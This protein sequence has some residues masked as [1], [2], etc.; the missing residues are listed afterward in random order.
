[1]TKTRSKR[2][3]IPQTDSVESL[4]LD[5]LHQVYDVDDRNGAR[6]VAKQL[7]KLIVAQPEYNGSIRGEEIRSLIAEV[8][9]DLPAAIES[10]EAEIRK[11]LELHSIAANTANYTYVLR[12]YD[13]S[14]VSDRLD[15]LAILYD[16]QGNTDRA[17]AI[18]I[19]SKRFCESHQILF[20]GQDLLD[21]LSD[22]NNGEPRPAAPAI[23]KRLLSAKRRRRP[24]S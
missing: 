13:F 14:D 11:I 8:R 21:E 2:E 23:K 1:M 9:G 10:R 17:I 24:A 16:Q 4:Y 12:Q 15:L 20:D 5:L 3:I 19:E 7:E 18:L 6:R 22:Q